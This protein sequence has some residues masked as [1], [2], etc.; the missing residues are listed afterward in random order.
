MKNKFVKIRVGGRGST[1]LWTMSLNILFFFRS[2]LN[3][4]FDS[5]TPS[6]RK[7]RDGEITTEKS[8]KKRMMEIVAT[9]VVASRPPNGDHLHRK[10]LVPIEEHTEK[11]PIGTGGTCSPSAMPH[12]LQNSKCPPSD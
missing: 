7:G 6:M 4:F 2:P 10:L 8:R 5:G 1:S 12:Q 3:K 11:I 9:N